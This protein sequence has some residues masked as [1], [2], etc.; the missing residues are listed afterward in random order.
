MLIVVVSC[1]VRIWDMKTQQNVATFKG[2]EGGPVN[3]IAFSENGYYMASG[4]ADGTARLW[5]LRKLK[6]FHTIQ[7]RADGTTNTRNINNSLSL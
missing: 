3:S 1:Q 2:H 6:N 5:D 7:M 4:G